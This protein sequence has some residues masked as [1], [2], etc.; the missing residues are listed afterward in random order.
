MNLHNNEQLV[1][2]QENMG[3]I[4]KFSNFQLF[5]YLEK[6]ICR[7]NAEINFRSEIS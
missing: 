1:T 5:G 2:W 4:G 7:K 3:V 6:R